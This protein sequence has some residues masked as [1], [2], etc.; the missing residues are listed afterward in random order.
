MMT[1]TSGPRI[2]ASDAGKR[3]RRAAL[4]AGWKRSELVWERWQERA[5][6]YLSAGRRRRAAFRF[7]A[8][9]W[10]ALLAFDRSD[11][12]RAASTANAACAFRVLG[13]GW[14]GARFYRIAVRDWSG[15][16][17][18]FPGIAIQ[19]RAR[20]SLFHL[21]MEALHLETYTKVRKQRL[22]AFVDEAGECL[23]NLTEG[24]EPPHRLYSR[25]R[26]EKPPM[27]DDTRRILAACL[28]IAAPPRPPG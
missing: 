25:W 17:R 1:T 19:P 3:E 12:R 11:P 13:L 27:F 26:G 5:N 4:N 23:A 28:L 18:E 10:L 2:L 22:A 16:D 6:E 24:R 21:R 7:L 20:S 15:I 14:A 9:D 8:A